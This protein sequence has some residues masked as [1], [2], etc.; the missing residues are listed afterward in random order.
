MQRVPSLKLL[1]G[2]EAAARLGNF[3]RAADELHLSQS[4]VSHQIQQL[5]TH[6]GQ[7]LF[8]RRG[9]GVELT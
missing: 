7:P 6:L 9:R 5:E 8:R 4:A 1:T 3:S 2:F